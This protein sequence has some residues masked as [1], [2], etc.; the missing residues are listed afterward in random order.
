M[1]MSDLKAR[2]LMKTKIT[3]VRPDEKVAAVDL[4]MVRKSLGGVPILQYETDKLVGIVT[5]RDMMLSRFRTSIAG[6][7]VENLMTKNPI[8]VSPDVSIKEL[9]GLMLSHRIER[10]PVI[11]N[12]KLVGI[13]EPDSILKAVYQTISSDPKI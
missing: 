8:T 11:D 9:L 6:M 10:L 12:G 13:I 3:S 7:T 5:Q 1:S 2:D 4:L